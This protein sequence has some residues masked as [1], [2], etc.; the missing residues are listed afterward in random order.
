MSREIIQQSIRGISREI[1]LRTLKICG[2]VERVNGDEKRFVKPVKRPL[3]TM[4]MAL[5]L[6]REVEKLKVIKKSLQQQL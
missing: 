4:I 6:H 1:N 5:K 2:L 3:P